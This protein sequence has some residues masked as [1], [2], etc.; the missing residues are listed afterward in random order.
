MAQTPV[1]QLRRED[2]DDIQGLVLSG[3]KDMSHV[4]FLFVRLGQPAAARSWLRWLTDRVT[5]HT[6]ELRGVDR[7]QVAL[8][9]A[10]LE[11]LGVPA[12][13][14]DALPQEAKQ[15]MHWRARILGDTGGSAPEHWTLGVGEPPI[16]ALVMLYA[17]GEAHRAEMV[18][19]HRARLA[20]AG[21]T[22]SSLEESFPLGDSEHFGFADGLSQP[23]IAG[24]L[25]EDAAPTQHTV[26][27]GEI[28]LGYDNA[29]GRRPISP[30]LPDGF[31][32]GRNGSYLVFR[33]L[34]QDVAR[35]W[36]YFA[37]QARSLAGG[38][39]DAAAE[40]TQR[41]AAK[42]MG[43]W[44]SGVSLV[45]APDADPGKMPA[46][47]AEANRF[48]YLPTDRDGLACPVSSHVRRANPRDARGGSADE[49]FAVIRRH[50]ILRRGR[51]YG[52]PMPAAGPRG[53]YFVS[54]QSSI[55]R[56][57]EFIQQTWLSATSFNGTFQESD[58]VVGG[59]D[60][61]CPFTIPADPVRLRLP[62]VP[63]FVT[64]RGGGYFFL[65][66]RSALYRIA[67]G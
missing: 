51:S 45:D 50:R 62:E 28:L 19:E 20:E 5:P 41:L 59:A 36:Q 43:R 63:R 35:F 3:Y 15:G 14:L 6:K 21:G 17:D 38:D 8:T 11:L 30:M 26:A 37:D 29:Y 27:T 48:L 40:L 7:V 64:T 55:A 42:A 53:L 32:L 66:S 60:G 24:M 23:L 18:A 9:P 57:F 49:S 44:R 22:V 31:D 4:A 12:P 25:G 54:L 39:G 47:R 58:P 33:K 52:A 65:P 13:T 61:T 67:G 10:G 46:D 34:E 1:T 16:D 2:L 56:G